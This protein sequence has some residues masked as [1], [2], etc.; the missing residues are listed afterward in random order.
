MKNFKEMIAKA[1]NI[2]NK[3]RIA[4]ACPYD[5]NIL[6][7]LGRIQREGIGDVILLGDRDKVDSIK[8]KYNIEM[9]PVDFIKSESDI[10]A[11]KKS[12]AM[13]IEGQ[14]DIIMKGMVQTKDFMRTILSNKKFMKNKLLTHTVAF[15]IPSRD[16]LLFVTDPSIMTEPTLDQKKVILDNAVELLQYLGIEEPKVAIISSVEVPNEAIK[17]SMD[18]SEL[19]ELQK[20]DSI[21][22][23]QV[24]GPLAIDNAVSKEAAKLKNINSEV[25]GN[26]DLLL[27][28][29]LDAGNIFCK[30]LVY[31]GE[32]DT[33]G[34]VMGAHKPIVLTSRSAGVDERFN[35]ICIACV[36]AEKMK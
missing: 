24:Y 35:S 14:A 3:P 7:A 32:F 1:K 17:S 29:N 11:L 36:L 4:I 22:N 33:G 10:Q 21:W 26:A 6:E 28:P 15:D 18:G 8:E 27:M 30:G 12:Y 34:I 2:E 31:I 19:M 25:A 16:K 5:K 23:A 9:D 13:V 20:K